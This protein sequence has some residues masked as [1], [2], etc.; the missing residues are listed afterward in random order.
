MK[1]Q[2]AHSHYVRTLPIKIFIHILYSGL[3]ASYS[4]SLR[5]YFVSRD[6][7]LHS[8]VTQTSDNFSF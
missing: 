3:A 6:T 1:N 7:T 8:E 5:K 4:S 2:L